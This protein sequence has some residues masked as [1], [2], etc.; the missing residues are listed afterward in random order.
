MSEVA[1][2]LYTLPLHQF[3][4]YLEF[5]NWTHVNENDRWILYED[6]DAIEL[7]IPK[8]RHASD[9]RMYVDHALKILSFAQDK[10]PDAVVDD[11]MTF[12][13]DVFGAI[14]DDSESAASILCEAQIRTSRS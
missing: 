14:L 5:E 8:K 4:A 11:I 10:E 3:R 6:I 9:F 2:R 7:A 1:S 12:D 13:L